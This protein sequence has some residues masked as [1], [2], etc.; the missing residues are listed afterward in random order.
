[1]TFKSP[2]LLSFLAYSSFAMMDVINKFLFSSYMV[3]FFQYMLLLDL[4]IIFFIF[5]IGFLSFKQSFKFLYPKNIKGI[6]IRS[7][8]SVIN[9][10]CSLVAISYLPFHLFYTLAF[11]QPI[12][13]V[14]FASIFGLETLNFKKILIIA[15]GFSGILISIEFWHQS[16]SNFQLI[17]ITGGLGISISGALSGIIVKKYLKDENISTIGSYNILLSIIV[18]SIYLLIKQENPFINLEIN[19]IGLILCAGLFCCF[20]I[21]FFMKSYQGGYINS[22]AILQY[23]QIL[24]GVGFGY[25]LF[26]NIPSVYGIIGAIII[27]IANL[28]N[29]K[30][31]SNK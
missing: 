27:I 29:L 22:I 13:V 18:A 6:A 21:L 25:L 5:M 3:G 9:T 31:Q 15:L 14:I 10:L 2:I 28:L 20:G 1:M 19:F 16:F 4:A 23:T 26:Q 17:G 8:I 12:F 30:K 11:L 7:V 24:W